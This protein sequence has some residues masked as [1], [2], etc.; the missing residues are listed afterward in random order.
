[1]NKN[2]IVIAWVLFILLFI[3]FVGVC[4]LYSNLKHMNN[5]PEYHS[6]IVISLMIILL[7]M[8]CYVLLNIYLLYNYRE[9][10]TEPEQEG[11]ETV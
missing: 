5:I 8:I 1:M 3:A 2:K 7:I 11:I 6:S 9:I 10:V 4:I